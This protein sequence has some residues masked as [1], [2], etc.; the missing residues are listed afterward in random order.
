MSNSSRVLFDFADATARSGWRNVDDVVMG[1]VSDSDLI[2]ASDA[3]VAFEGHVSLDHGGG[4]ASVRSPRHTWD[5]SGFAGI[6]FR[7][8]GD[9]KRYKLTLYTNDADGISYR[10]P[11]TT[12]TN[13][14]DYFVPFDALT[15]MRRGRHVPDAPVFDPAA[16]SAVGFL[17]A[18]EQAGPF[19]LELRWIQAAAQP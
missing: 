14:N 11:F 18:D 19:R 2:V 10:F 12:E 13:W 5:L 16:V 17:I 8:R 4:F 15:P 3:T 1:G 7:A 9:G 6:R